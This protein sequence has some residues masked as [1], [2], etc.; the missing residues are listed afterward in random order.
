MDG[1]FLGALDLRLSGVMATSSGCQRLAGAWGFGKGGFAGGRVGGG[2]GSGLCRHGA[3][4]GAGDGGEDADPD[5]R[6]GRP[7]AVEKEGEE[8]RGG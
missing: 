1:G 8:E 4:G 3:T 5:G 2:G 6:G 7:C